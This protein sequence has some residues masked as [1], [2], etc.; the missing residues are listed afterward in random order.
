[1][2]KIRLLAPMLLCLAAIG[3]DDIVR[4]EPVRGQTHLQTLAR[5]DDGKFKEWLS[6]W[7]AN[8]LANLANHYCSKESGEDM[9]W[10]MYPMLRGFYYGYITTKNPRWVALTV[11][12]A[13]TWIRQAQ[14]EPDGYIGWP[15]VG[16]AGTNVDRLDDFYADS[17]LGEAMV[18]Q[19]IVLMSGE[20]LKTPPLADNFSAKAKSY[21]KLAEQVF[22]KW[23]KRGAWRETSN[24]NMVTVELPFG[25]DKDTRGWTEGYQTRNDPG[26]GF[27]HQNNKANLIACWLLAMS[28]VTDEPVYKERAKKWF[29][30][31]K[32][33]IRPKD[34]DT[35]GIWNYWEPAGPWD[36]KAHLL[37]KHW[38][39]VHQNSAY[40]AIDVESILTAY[41]HG[42]VFTREDV[43][44]LIKT[45]L[46]QNKYWPALALYN[47][48]I[49]KMFEERNDPSSWGGLGATPWY[50]SY[51]VQLRKEPP[52][53]SH[54]K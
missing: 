52:S 5:M 9:G 38:I 49:Q 54:T 30:V 34:S 41:E 44:R 42:I 50:L 3:H 21:I 23:D 16:A 17:M 8:I 51:Q 36:Y 39:G 14:V 27:S 35:V 45:A 46:T 13:D 1:M 24:G 40:Y 29:L 33:R 7:Q 15:K 47:P 12:C 25:I 43:D 48:T 26:I 4:S 18:L 53:E 19:Y 20:I 28:D 2:I 11:S 32:S 37:P 22:E 10:I 6:R 31:M